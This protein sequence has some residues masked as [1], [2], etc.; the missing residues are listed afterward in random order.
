MLK[1]TTTNISLKEK[2][3]LGRSEESIY[4]KKSQLKKSKC[5]G[6]FCVEKSG[7]GAVSRKMT[8]QKEQIRPR[9]INKRGDRKGESK[10]SPEIPDR[11]G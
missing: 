5:I 3:F 8:R 11:Y 1:Q 2:V 10:D 4:K 6:K 9:E 7:D